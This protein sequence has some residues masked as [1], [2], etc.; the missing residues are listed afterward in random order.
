MLPYV[1]KGT[2][3]D[4]RFS[5]VYPMK[6]KNA[7]V[8]LVRRMSAE[9]SPN[10]FWT[11]DFKQFKRISEL[12]PEKKYNWLTSELLK[13]K[14]DDGIECQGILYKPQ[15]FDPHKKYPVIFN[16]YERVTE[17]LHA[18]LTSEVSHGDLN[19]PFFVSNG[20]LVF[21]PDIRYE[22]GHPGKSVLK[23][24]VSGANYLSQ[25]LYVDSKHMGLQGHSRGGW[26]TNFLVTHTNMFAAA[27][28][29]CG[30]SNYIS[31]YNGTRLFTSGA[32]RQ[33]AFEMGYQRIGATLWER[34][35]L[36]IENSPIFRAHLV[37]T[38]LLLLANKNDEDVP[39][40]Q[41]V[42]FFSA[43]R[44]L[45]KKVWMLQ[46]DGQGHILFNKA[47]EDFTLKMKQFF[48]YYL[49][50]DSAPEWMTIG[51]PASKK[52]FDK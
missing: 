36:Y 46:Y 49:K 19:I 27:I 8:Y 23:T 15:N 51:I 33:I 40:E 4:E 44:R 31:L 18:F 30:M 2:W 22:I 20:Y 28:S 48:D 45:K 16:Y 39:F 12:E 13:W 41:G 34:P 50:G 1:F 35:D 3:E 11:S 17:G 52:G 10:Y 29:A 37:N 24:I 5:P 47:A 21:T 42:E 25:L 32:S 14:T 43:L 9:E 7:N 26:E 6:A 38:P